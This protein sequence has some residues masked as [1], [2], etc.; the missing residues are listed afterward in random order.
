MPY[1]INPYTGA[2]NHRPIHRC[3][4]S[5]THTQV[6]YIIDP[7]TAATSWLKGHI[8]TLG[9]TLEMTTIQDA[10]FTTTMELAVRFGKTLVVDEVDFVE[11][12]LY[13]VLRKDLLRQGTRLMVQIGEKTIDYNENFRLYLSTRNP[14]PIIPPDAASLVGVTNFTVTHSG[15]QSQLLGVT[16]QH[17]QPEL[18]KQKSS[19]LAQEEELK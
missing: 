6:P 19:L 18:E 14:Y 10:R 13:T 15:L 17:E 11:P 8:K 3:L 16:I 2:L 12:V 5:S 7:S 9:G 1:I 4:T